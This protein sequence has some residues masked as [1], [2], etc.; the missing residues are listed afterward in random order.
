MR[1]SFS[2]RAVAVTTR[3]PH[4]I[5][6]ACPAPGRAV[7]QTVC[8]A[9]HSVGTFFSRLLPSPRGPRQTG[10]FS[11]AAKLGKISKPARRPAKITE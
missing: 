1:S 7:F 4:T 10:Q 9:F 3:L 2:G 5:A 6:E 11:A 8:A